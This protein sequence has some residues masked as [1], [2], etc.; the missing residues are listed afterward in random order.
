MPFLQAGYAVVITDVRGT[1]ASFGSRTT[2]FSPDEVR[3]GWDVLDWIVA[4]SWSDGNVG[5][6]GIS[7]PGT[8]AELIG[9][10]GHPALKAVAPMFS[11]YDF[12]DDVIRPGGVFLDTF[13][14]QWATLVRGMDSNIFD[15]PNGPVTGVRPVDGPNGGPLLAAAIAEHQRNASI[16]DQARA[17]ETRGD[18]DASGLSLDDIS[19]HRLYDTLSRRIPIYNYGGWADGFANGPIKR[20]LAQPSPGSRLIMGPWNHGGSWSYYPMRGPVRSQFDQSRELLRFFDYHLRGIST[21]IESEPPVWYFTTG[22]NAWKSA[23]AWPVATRDTVLE[24]FSNGVLSQRPW[25]QGDPHA[26]LEPAI[27]TATGTGNQSR[28]NTILGGRG[29]TNPVRPRAARGVA[30]WEWGPLT[31][32]LSVSGRPGG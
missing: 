32:D 29:V 30:V 25:K 6:M 13:F 3:D 14:R 10:L 5:A 1:G 4:Q 7:Y 31:A 21:G 11:I 8:T 16:Y 9:T 19:P 15:P 24:A 28:W 22:E 27:D 20:F 12:Y 17:L 23:A 2:E 18:R 26:L